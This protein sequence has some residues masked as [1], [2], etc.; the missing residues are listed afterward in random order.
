MKY[1]RFYHYTIIRRMK[2]EEELKN[3]E[4]GSKKLGFKTALAHLVINKNSR[5]GDV[6]DG[7][8]DDQDGDDGDDDMI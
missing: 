3:H 5:P 4:P 6:D 1:M 8:I 2:N 7:N